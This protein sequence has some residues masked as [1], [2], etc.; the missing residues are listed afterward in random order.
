MVDSSELIDNPKNWRLHPPAQKDALEAILEE[1]G[2]ADALLARETDEGLMLIDGHLRKETLPS[3]EVP[4][5]ILDV[6]E[7]EADKMLLTLDPMASMAIRDEARLTQLLNTVNVQ[8]EALVEML[9]ALSDD[10]LQQ[11]DDFPDFGELLDENIANN[12]ELCIC[13]CGNE[14]HK[15]RE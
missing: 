1:V 7:E 5:L 10:A 6:D 12:I 9:R 13:E 4:V 3:E 8:D 15:P 2:I 14:H 11:L